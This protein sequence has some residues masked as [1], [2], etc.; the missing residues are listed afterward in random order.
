MRTSFEP[1]SVLYTF[2]VSQILVPQLYTRLPCCTHPDDDALF[3]RDTCDRSMCKGSDG[4]QRLFSYLCVLVSFVR[5]CRSLWNLAC[6]ESSSRISGFLTWCHRAQHIS[7]LTCAEND[8]DDDF[9]WRDRSDCGGQRWCTC[10]EEWTSSGY[11]R[12]RDKR[13]NSSNAVA[14]AFVF[15]SFCVFLSS[16]VFLFDVVLSIFMLFSHSFLLLFPCCFFRYFFFVF[17]FFSLS[18]FFLIFPCFVLFCFQMVL[19]AQYF[20]FDHLMCFSLSTTFFSPLHFF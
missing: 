11:R 7:L 16:F 13:G 2:P 20:Y 5:Q 10:I 12:I 8:L 18:F 3:Q 1:Q 15:S 6:S 17:L 4:R 14:H 9:W 19:F